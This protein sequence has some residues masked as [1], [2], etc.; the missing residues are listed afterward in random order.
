M[1]KY[2]NM[3]ASTYSLN[4]NGGSK[5]TFV[6]QYAPSIQM[7]LTPAQINSLSKDLSVESIYYSPE[8]EISANS[9][10]GNQYTYNGTIYKGIVPDAMVYATFIS[11][12][13]EGERR[14][15][16]ECAEWLIGRGV[17]IINMSMQVD[18]NSGIYG[19]DDRWADHIALQ[20]RVHLVVAAGNYNEE[21]GKYDH[22]VTT[23]AL[24]YNVITVGNLDD[25]GSS[26]LL[27]DVIA[28]SSCYLDGAN[29]KNAHK[30]DIVAPGTDI[31]TPF[32]QMSGTSFAA[33]YITGIVAQL[34]QA[35]ATLKTNPAT[36]KAI[37][38]ASAATEPHSYYIEDDN[39]DKYGA[40]LVNA[41]YAYNI[42]NNGR[43]ESDYFP[44]GTEAGMYH[45]H[46]FNISSA[47][48]KVKVALIW[49]NYKYV[50]SDDHNADAIT[51]YTMPDLD[52][53]IYDDYWT[54]CFV[55]N[56]T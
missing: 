45:E 16:R 27:D 37:L 19:A 10:L 40:G 56:N 6:S 39:Y 46:S 47:A 49:L 25:N 36:V 9:V 3:F 7:E 15:W 51:G 17:N 29:S 24:A 8:L 33:P 38:C 26:N 34:C 43:Y 18:S 55:K 52:V 23:P 28:S 1:D 21:I 32:G 50:D 44:A 22:Y 4:D 35:D 20:H 12:N 48:S 14:S 2:S 11:L 30:P 54:L 13:E 41:Q 42:T 31:S 5:V 53:R